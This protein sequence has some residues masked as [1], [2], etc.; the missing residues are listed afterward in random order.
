VGGIKNM[1]REIVKITTFLILI[2]SRCSTY[3]FIYDFELVNVESSLFENGKERSYKL[4][5]NEEAEI[6]KILVIAQYIPPNTL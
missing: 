2:F 5:K 3:S 1:S 4:N 6:L